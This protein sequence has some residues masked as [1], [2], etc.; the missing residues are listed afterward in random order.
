M[1]LPDWISSG[2]VLQV[3]VF[4]LSSDF[5]TVLWPLAQSE[6]WFMCLIE[7]DSMLMACSSFCASGFEAVHCEDGEGRAGDGQWTHQAKGSS[8]NVWP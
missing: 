2:P 4:R 1:G 7:I 8:D 3:A 5:E 6:F